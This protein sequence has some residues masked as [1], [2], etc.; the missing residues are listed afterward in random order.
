VELDETCRRQQ[1]GEGWFPS[2]EDVPHRAISMSIRQ[3]MR[4]KTIIC[5]VPDERKAKAVQGAVESEVTPLIP[6]TV[7][8]QHPATWLFLD[9]ASASL[10]TK[11]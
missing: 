11:R 9:K 6:A 5:S 8:Q 3:I 2:L 10:L 4:S 7:L 1:L